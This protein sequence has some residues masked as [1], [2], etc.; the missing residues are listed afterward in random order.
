MGLPQTS[1]ARQ[2]LKSPSSGTLAILDQMAVRERSTSITDKARATAS[3]S[4]DD[5]A[6]GA[7]GRLSTTAAPHRRASTTTPSVTGSSGEG[8]KLSSFSGGA[9]L[10][11]IATKQGAFTSTPPGSLSKPAGSTLGASSGAGDAGSVSGLRASASLSS[12]P[13][14]AAA[15]A[16]AAAEAEVAN[17]AAAAAASHSASV[18][19]SALHLSMIRDQITALLNRT[20][21]LVAPLGNEPFDL[22]TAANT[23][24]ADPTSCFYI[25]PKQSPLSPMSPGSSTAAGGRRP[26][27]T[28][29]SSSSSVD[30][31][32]EAVD[33][34]LGVALSH[35]RAKATPVT[36]L[37]E[38]EV[39]IFVEGQAVDGLGEYDPD[40]HVFTWTMKPMGLAEV[41]KSLAEN[42][43][44]SFFLDDEYA[45]RCLRGTIAS[46]RTP[47]VLRSLHTHFTLA[48]VD[49]QPKLAEAQRRLLFFVN[50]LFMRLP[51]PP[52]VEAMP[53]WTVLTPFY[54]EDVL[55]SRSD[56]EKETED[57]VSQLLYLQ[58]IFPLEWGYFLERVG[59]D[60]TAYAA[61][62]ATTTTIPH[63]HMVAA[64]L[65]ATHRGQTL[66]RTVDR[67]MAYEKAVQLL[68]ELEAPAGQTQQQQQQPQNTRL[69]SP[70]LSASPGRGAPILQQQQYHHHHHHHHQQQQ[71]QQQ[72]QSL[73]QQLTPRDIGW[74]KFNYV[75]ACQVYGKQRKELDPKAAD[76]D[77]LLMKHPNLRVAYI[78]QQ[79]VL[80]KD[81][82]TGK[83]STEEQFFSVLIRARPSPTTAAATAATGTGAAGVAAGA[84]GVG[85][86]TSPHVAAGS[87]AVSPS[88]VAAAAAAA[89]GSG[90][91]VIEEVFRV[92]LPGDPVLGEGK[93]ENQ[94][95]AII[96][97]RGERI[98]AIDMNQ[99]N[100]LDD[101]LKLRNLLGEFRTRDSLYSYP[102]GHPSTATM[103][104]DGKPTTIVGFRE[105]IFTG[106]LSSIAQ[107]MALQEATF[108]TLGQRVL[109]DPLRARMHYGHPDLFD[110]LYFMARGGVSKASRALNLSEDIF[111]GYNTTL[112]GGTVGFA[113]YVQVGKGRDVGLQQ[114]FKFEAKLAQ[115]AAMQS[116]TR[117]VHRLGATLDIA[118][119]FTFCFGGLGFYIGNCFVIWALYGFLQARILL[120]LFGADD[121]TAM[122]GTDT[123]AYW[124][125]SFAFLLTLPVF[126]ELGLEH[127]FR[128]ATAQ[129]ARML[130][131]GGPLYYMFH[132]GTKFHFY[133][134][135]LL[136]GGATYRPTGRGFVT[137]HENFP[138]IFRFHCYSH[139]YYAAELFI[140]LLVY[141]FVA[142]AGTSYAAITWPTWL[143]TTSWLVGPFW[144]NPMAFEWTKTVADFQLFM[145]WM[146]RTEGDSDQCWIKWRQEEIAYLSN[147]APLQSLLLCLTSTRHAILGVALMYAWDVPAELIFACVV[148]LGATLSTLGHMGS[149]VRLLRRQSGRMRALDAALVVGLVASVIFFINFFN[150]YGFRF[151]QTITCL[152]SIL[153]ISTT[154]LNIALVSGLSLPNSLDESEGSWVTQWCKLFDLAIGMSLLS[155]IALF[156]LI[157]VPGILQTRLMFHNAF[158]QG[159]LVDSL[160]R[161][162]AKSK[163]DKD[164]LDVAVATAATASATAKELSQLFIESRQSASSSTSTS[165]STSKS[166]GSRGTVGG[167]SSLPS[168]HRH[169]AQHGHDHDHR[170]LGGKGTSAKNLLADKVYSAASSPS[171]NKP[172]EGYGSFFTS[173]GSGEGAVASGVKKEE[174]GLTKRRKDAEDDDDDD[175]DGDGA[176]HSDTDTEPEPDYAMRV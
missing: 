20:S 46:P 83:V 91:V 116:L 80:K 131:T 101:G 30:D 144:F 71:Q 21:Q 97:T 171:S 156:S 146:K 81:P 75:V 121:P 158:S 61:G 155:V 154:C 24:R 143:I 40:H 147:L 107:Y 103:T 4:G 37:K 130:F 38:G 94:N 100:S 85:L 102:R 148:F 124:F 42:A 70:I 48:V 19:A 52:P 159:V 139:F 34:V 76:I 90:N 11:L 153:L 65:W 32:A 152:F 167:A 160:L 56:L 95:H 123:V 145:T 54:S 163:A 72:Q 22:M 82:V 36:A 151:A 47:L 28:S 86:S 68:A 69:S 27:S 115:G 165:T 93:P 96:F 162:T 5:D 135:T 122:A 161:G 140:L 110:K 10:P 92:R 77:Y 16:A 106:A 118:R 3:G 14:A 168:P 125:G 18:A 9:F 67:M 164:K 51:R 74:M 62:S 57:G 133:Q 142:P 35:V 12:L 13:A 98:Q 105:H 1:V 117:D 78:D 169:G 6:A 39:H 58:T 173:S 26:F 73:A 138:E 99:D 8:S 50:S 55:Y 132:M 104:E 170:S 114:L 157:V 120:A 2:L 149:R 174:P 134:H 109:A 137:R 53:S 17:A 166:S 126:T 89:P 41:L 113:E 44:G 25:P 79:R 64:R 60:A 88:V 141:A 175:D 136:A 7:G 45:D 29:S 33:S 49:A 43:Q 15:A 129:V 23:M 66:C 119:L 128:N 127:G 59:L 172:L 108:V 112:R 84:S 150:I 63:T 31:A 87:S 176:N 111:A